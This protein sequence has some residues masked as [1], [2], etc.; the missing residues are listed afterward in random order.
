MKNMRIICSNKAKCLL[1]ND[2]IES[3]H[4]HHFVKCSCGNIF[5]DGGKSEYKRIGCTVKGTFEDTSEVYDIDKEFHLLR[6]KFTWTSVYDKSG[7]PL[8]EHVTQVLKD[9][10][11]NHLDALIL[12]T[13]KYTY[14]EEVQSVLQKEKE[15]RIGKR[16]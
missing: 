15:F 6:E 9:I 2:E 4:Q 16:E 12:W 10:D 7:N 3:K 8:T 11:D 14:S 1:C 13:T 5:I